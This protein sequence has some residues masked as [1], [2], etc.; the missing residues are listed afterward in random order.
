[1]EPS[2]QDPALDPSYLG[3]AE[4]GTDRPAWA[5]IRAKVAD[6]RSW[7]VCSTRVDG[8]PH[9]MPVWGVWIDDRPVF[10]TGRAT[11][12]ARNLLAGPA[13]TVH[14]ESGDDV[15][16]IEGRAV[17]V[18]FG[19]LPASLT[20]SYNQKYGTELDL[21]DPGS[22]F[23]AIEMRRVFSWDEA[24]FVETATRWQFPTG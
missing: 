1:M 23:F 11:I 4:L 5:E 6:A 12:K 22:V 8:R 19:D 16:I 20:D 17:K 14:L 21:D 13:V 3:G 2:P 9:A 15:V 24:R 10:A 7:W 18:A